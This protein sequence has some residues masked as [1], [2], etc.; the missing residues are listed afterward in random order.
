MIQMG[1]V[2]FSDSFPAWI[3][4]VVSVLR[5]PVLGFPF[6]PIVLETNFLS[7][8]PNGSYLVVDFRLFVVDFAP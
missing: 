5:C 6:G 1:Q 8:P 7:S 3:E 4:N 2:L